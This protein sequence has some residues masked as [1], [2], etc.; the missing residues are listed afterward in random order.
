MSASY[1]EAD[2]SLNPVTYILRSEFTTV[3]PEGNV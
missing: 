2:E 1:C 3:I